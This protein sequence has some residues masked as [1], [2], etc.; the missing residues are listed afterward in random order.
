MGQLDPR[1]GPRPKINSRGP[2]NDGMVKHIKMSVEA[3]AS[4]IEFCDA[5]AAS[6]RPTLFKVS[7][8]FQF[9]WIGNGVF[10]D[11]HECSAVRR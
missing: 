1:D 2:L 4:T 5:E 3:L 9:E 7:L 11:V 8:N 10:Q 6:I